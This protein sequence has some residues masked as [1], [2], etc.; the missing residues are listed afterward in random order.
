MWNSELLT[1]LTSLNVVLGSSSPRRQ[2]ILLMNLG[3]KNFTVIPSL[4][5]ENLS[6][7]G[8]EAGDY[9]RETAKHKIPSIVSSLPHDVKSLLI[10]AD[11]IISCG[12]RIFEKPETAQHQWEMFRFY[13]KH[14][15]I[16]VLTSIH[17]CIV[18][19]GV[20]IDQREKIEL[21]SLRFD[22]SLSNDQLEFYIGSREGLNVAG[23]FK[24]QGMG[25]MLFKGFQGDYYNIIG[26]PVRST[27]EIIGEILK[28]QNFKLPA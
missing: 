6:K 20:I 11:T 27:Y 14:R 18:Q 5:E 9:V 4:F 16:N 22:S 8:I 21:T 17:V 1:K 3:I 13:Q 12:G 26:L 24:F 25:S 19:S 2:E 23:G 28:D 15:E 7:Q 10:V